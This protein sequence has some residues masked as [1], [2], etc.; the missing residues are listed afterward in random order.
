MCGVRAFF[1]MFLFCFFLFFI[2]LFFV[3]FLIFACFF[4]FHFFFLSRATM[5]GVVLGL[6][7]V[8][9]CV[10]QCVCV[11]G[12]VRDTVC[13][14]D[15]CAHQC[16]CGGW[17]REQMKLGPQTVHNRP[18]SMFWRNPRN[19]ALTNRTLIYLKLS[20]NKFAGTSRIKI[21]NHLDFISRL[22]RGY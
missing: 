8:N 16:V 7:F 10:Q 22:A 21:L 15:S 17:V 2:F 4:C 13:V 9:V 11:C 3:Y 1:F 5:C 14:C 19:F 18:F 12:N 20:V 6:S